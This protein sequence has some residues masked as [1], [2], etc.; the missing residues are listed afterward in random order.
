[1]PSDSR[2]GLNPE[3]LVQLMRSA[4]DRSHLDL[5]GYRVLTEAASGAYA[6]TPVLAAMA[7][8][9]VIALATATKY[10]TTEELRHETNVLAELAGVTRQIDLTLEKTVEMVA[11][12]DIITN[13]GQIRPIDDALISRMKVSAVIPLMYESWEFRSSDVD[14]ASCHARGISVAG[15]NERHPSVDVFSYLGLMA[16]KQLHDAGIAVYRSRV[17]LLCDN[18]FE[19]FIVHGLQSCGAEVVVSDQLTSD[20]L[21]GGC[22]AV[23]LAMH[24]SGEP[25][26]THTDARLLQDKAPGSV[27]VQYWGDADRRSLAAANIPVWPPEAPQPGHMAVLPSAIGPEPIVRLQTGGLKVGEILLRGLDRSSAED[28][29]LVQ[30]L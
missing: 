19:P 21:T 26:I 10:A 14:L 8:A 6:V 30:L 29:S 15:T 1:M 25:L 5:F 11:T 17:V 3:R 13:S 16:V 7:G 28:R 23:L 9:T 24:P 22:D 2:P 18:Q 4:I 20:L 27:F 12:A